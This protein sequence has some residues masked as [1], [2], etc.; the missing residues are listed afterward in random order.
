MQRIGN[1]GSK[2]S[3]DVP[4]ITSI[5]SGRAKRSN[6]PLLVLNPSPSS[7]GHSVSLGVRGER[8]GGEKKRWGDGEKKKRKGKKIKETGRKKEN[9]KNMVHQVP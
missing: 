4:K 5:V 2:P 7:L 6:Y 1:C 8:M 9:L 3:H